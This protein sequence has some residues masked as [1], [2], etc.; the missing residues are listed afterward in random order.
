[1]QCFHDVPSRLGPRPVWLAFLSTVSDWRRLVE[2]EDWDRLIE[3][4]R[5]PFGLFT[6]TSDPRHDLSAWSEL[7][8]HCVGRELVL[9]ASWGTN[10]T[11]LDDLFD[12]VAVERAVQRR[13]GSMP[14][15]SWHDDEPLE[16]AFEFFLTSPGT[17]LRHGD[18]PGTDW[19]RIAVVVG[20]P[21]WRD[22]LASMLSA[23]GS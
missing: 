15:T 11:L 23:H 17:D 19:V 20:E 21:S 14:L 13:T 16:E 9:T 6:A 1:M 8:D 4:E 18:S 10:T 22:E 5:R 7:T 3:R 12:E 2:G